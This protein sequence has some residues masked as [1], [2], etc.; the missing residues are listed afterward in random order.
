MSLRDY[1][2]P[3]LTTD[4]VLMRIS[5]TVNKNNR[6]N[7]SK[8]LEVLLIKRNMEPQKDRWS[9]PG[10]FVDIDEE[11][12]ANVKRKL[13]EKTGITGNFYM[14]QL[15]TW[16]GINRDERG[17]VVSVSYLGLVNDKTY[18]NEGGSAEQMWVDVYEA[19]HMDLAFDH[20]EIII[21]AMQRIQNKAE[22]TDILM[23]LMPE[24][25]TIKDCQIVYEVALNKH[26]DNFKRRVG[27]YL[28]E[29]DKISEGK[30]YRPA[31]LFKWNK[32]D[33]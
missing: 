31:K 32:E 14:E 18:K 30:Q 5:E 1:E 20:K 29:T 4:I 19:M 15:Y 2:R 25:F 6:K 17:R 22:Y 33:K 8:H 23:N 11:I 9:L 21:Y 12:G 26:M 3:S 28:I 16:G 10:G 13:R 24:E 7:N 27:K